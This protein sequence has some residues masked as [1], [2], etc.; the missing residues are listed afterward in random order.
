MTVNEQLHTPATIC[1][2]KEFV[3]PI[4]GHSILS[5]CIDLPVIMHQKLGSNQLCFKFC[6]N[7]VWL[8]IDNVVCV[9]T[10][11]L[12]SKN[13]DESTVL[14]FVSKVASTSPQ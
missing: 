12:A 13:G 4:L 7:H 8:L 6:F 3:Q 1:M 14:L 9:P 5:V 11:L 10:V 2:R